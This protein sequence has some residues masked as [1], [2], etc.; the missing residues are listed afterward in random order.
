M[1]QLFSP[2]EAVPAPTT[3]LTAQEA[4]QVVRLHTAQ[5]QDA[6]SNV[7]LESVAEL[8]HISLAEAATLL[9]QVRDSQQ[10]FMHRAASEHAKKRRRYIFLVVPLALLWA[11]FLW[12]GFWTIWRRSAQGRPYP[13]YSRH[14]PVYPVE[15]ASVA[16]PPPGFDVGVDA[17]SWSSSR[18]GGDWRSAVS[19]L[20]PSQTEYLQDKICASIVAIAETYPRAQERIGPD[21]ITYPAGATDIVHVNIKR[22]GGRWSSFKVSTPVG[23]FP[24]RPGESVFLANVKRVIQDHWA[25]ITGAN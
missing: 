2:H 3:S 18:S 17:G 9:R 8:L 23:T 7:T 4:E 25:E 10:A 6:G 24:P 16:M 1:A 14:Y 13:V 22:T 21:G 19:H 20:T 15:E 5:G 12:E 11:L